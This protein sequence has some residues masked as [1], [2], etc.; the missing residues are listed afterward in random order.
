MHSKD[1][2]TDSI[3]VVQCFQKHCKVSIPKTKLLQCFQNILTP[4]LVLPRCATLQSFQKCMPSSALLTPYCPFDFRHCTDKFYTTPPIQGT[5]DMNQSKIQPARI[6]PMILDVLL[7]PYAIVRNLGDK[8]IAKCGSSNS[9]SVS[10]GSLLGNQ[11]DQASKRCIRKILHGGDYTAAIW[12]NLMQKN[13][14]HLF[15]ATVL[16]R[17]D[18]VLQISSSRNARYEQQVWCG[19]GS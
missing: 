9:L 15:S 10:S 2:T 3:A 5:D 1:Q 7:A 6:P 18:F 14:D 13:P 4:C 16:P 11:I 8:F 12:A 19:R 17:G